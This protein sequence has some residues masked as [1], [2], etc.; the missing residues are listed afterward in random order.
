MSAERL[1]ELQTAWKSIIDPDDYDTHMRSIG[2]APTN[3]ELVRELIERN[4]P[5]GGNTI[6]FAGAGS[7]QMFDFVDAEFLSPYEVTFSDIS[8]P[9]LEALKPRIE[10]AGLRRVQVLLDDLT[11]TKLTGPYS[12]AVVVL[13]LEHLD[14]K[15][16]LES[17]N[18]LVSGMLWIVIQ[19][20]P[21]SIATA[22]TPGRELPGTMA[23]V[24][25]KAQP[26]LL[27]EGELTAALSELGFEKTVTAPRP[28]ADGKEMVGL[29]YQRKA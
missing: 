23:V 1:A 17:L 20:N 29:V 8:A 12:G 15:A 16:A 27:D 6:L 26:H 21:E 9:F 11:Q 19:R 10:F 14:W 22:V 25:D 24:G 7:G 28:V 5:T 18:R 2:Q 13:V 4:P 3:A